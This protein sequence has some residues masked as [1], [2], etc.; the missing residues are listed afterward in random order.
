MTAA[1]PQTIDYDEIWLALEGEAERLRAEAEADEPLREGAV[2]RN[3][4]T[5]EAAPAR[6]APTSTTSAKPTPSR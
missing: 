4:R 5:T 3:P 1:D 6:A 2:P